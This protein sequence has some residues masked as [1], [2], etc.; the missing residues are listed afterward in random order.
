MKDAKNACIIYFVENEKYI[1]YAF[2]IVEFGFSSMFSFFFNIL[3]IRCKYCIYYIVLLRQR[4]VKKYVPTFQ[5]NLDFNR[6]LETRKQIFA[7]KLLH[8]LFVHILDIFIIN[9][10]RSAVF[11]TNKIQRLHRHKRL[12]FNENGI[13]S[14]T[15]TSFKIA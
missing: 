11:S 5:N 2:L 10:F 8:N 12:L 3:H 4:L 9:I 13:F 15:C 14:R 1:I 6:T 7:T